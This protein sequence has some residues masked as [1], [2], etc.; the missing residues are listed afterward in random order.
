MRTHGLQSATALSRA[1]RTAGRELLESTTAP[2]PGVKECMHILQ[3][4][5][6][7]DQ[8]ALNLDS[9][10]VA[11]ATTATATTSGHMRSEGAGKPNDG[12]RL[13]IDRAWAS[14]RAHQSFA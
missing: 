9:P 14:E 10:K 3:T 6:Q 12:A 7:P 5:H 1:E 13:H 2:Q 4:L 11:A 8:Q